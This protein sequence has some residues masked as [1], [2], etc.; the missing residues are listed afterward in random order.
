MVELRL[1]GNTGT[2]R[3]YPDV[4]R[5]REDLLGTPERPLTR[6]VSREHPFQLR[7]PQWAE[8]TIQRQD[9]ASWVGVPRRA[10]G[11]ALAPGTYRVLRG[12]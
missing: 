1:E 4:D 8:A 9:G 5:L 3:V 2:L 6:I 10:G 12:P 11:F 7:L